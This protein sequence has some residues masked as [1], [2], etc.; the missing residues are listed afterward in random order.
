MTQGVLWYFPKA[1]EEVAKVSAFGAQKY[2]VPFSDQNWMYVHDGINR[3]SDALAR[4]HLVAGELDEESGL[5][6]AAH[7]AWDA[8]AV[9]ELMLHKE[10]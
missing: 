1:I 2:E 8:L 10:E 3:Y 5:L 7:R 9:L 6:H 4:H